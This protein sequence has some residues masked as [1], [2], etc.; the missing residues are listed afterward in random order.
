MAANPALIP[1]QFV[2]GEE[3]TPGDIDPNGIPVD[4]GDPLFQATGEDGTQ[5]SE[6][7]GG[8]LQ[9]GFGPND[10]EALELSYAPGMGLEG[11]APDA[12]VHNA[13]LA[14]FME[15]TDLATIAQDVIEWEQIDQESRANWKNRIKEGMHLLGLIPE[16][17]DGILKN[18]EKV[19]HPLIAEGQVQFQARTMGELVPPTGPA[20]GDVL[21]EST[22]ELEDQA[23]RVADY[24]NYQLM[25]LDPDWYMETDR[26]LFIL[27]GEGSQF[28]KVFVDPLTGR[29]VSRWIRTENFAVPYGATSLHTTPRYTERI[30][31]YRNDM[32]KL[33]AS[34]HYRKV[35]LV[36][37]TDAA[38]TSSDLQEARDQA[39]GEERHQ[40]A[41]QNDT[42]HT[43]LDCVC[44]L[45]LPGF[46][47]TYPLD[48]EDPELAGTATGIALPYIVSVDKDS[49]KVLAIRR[50]WK[51]ND[52]QRL[53]RVQIVH[54]PFLP[55]DG[56]YSYGLWHM[57]GGLG[58]AATGLL[59]TI[60]IGAAFASM[61][62]GF[63][64]KGG[65]ADA[66]IELE[67]GK[68]KDVD[69]SFEE[70]TRLF[71]TP[72]FKE[73]GEAL[74]KV[75]GLVETAAQRFSS[76]TESMVGDASNTGPVGTTVALIEQGSKIYTGIHKRL[77]IAQGQELK[78]L[79]ELNGETLPEEG[80]PYNVKG[81]SR[82]AFRT[83]F[84][85][86]VDVVPVS[87][88]NIFSS[89]QR[90]SMAQTVVQRADVAPDLYDRKEAE[91]RFLDAIKVP[92]PDGVLAKIAQPTRADPVTENA[93]MLV[94]MPVA[95]FV[96]QDHDAH[97]TVV[98]SL[99]DS[100]VT[101]PQGDP[102]AQKVI[103]AAFAHLA[104]HM[105]YGMRAKVALQIGM[106][107]PPMT[108]N[109]PEGQPV[110]PPL[111]PQI[112]N[113]IAQMAA[114]AI[115]AMP[116][117]QQPGG[118]LE[119]RAAQ[120]EQEAQALESERQSIKGEAEKLDWKR[121]EAALMGQ[122]DGMKQ[123]AAGNKIIEEA[124][125]RIEKALGKGQQ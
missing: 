26:M 123:Q 78:L 3:L 112:E 13:N 27:A 7:P 9:V 17:S 34:G 47:D 87:D 89:T 98:Q 113:Q 105:A 45:D 59:K 117:P 116:K 10:E 8:A 88:P 33:Q 35:D 63:K 95:V 14:E 61:Q 20:K 100:M 62:G 74:F 96:D 76:T 42:E 110:T 2:P 23:E 51:E 55:G 67:W 84:D 37:P 12:M 18:V 73:P 31:V 21:G 115:A 4:I 68:Y 41:T 104:E 53:R 36:E 52:P 83:D 82:E 92:D 119:Q 6:L 15:E 43:V 54:Y 66:D 121:R 25:T 109:P 97:M 77:H 57:I 86:R 75:L 94:G 44:E 108:L 5:L 56:F 124:L 38:M 114:M 122:I 1:H 90:I 24:L 102:I 106:Q 99:I 69:M 111:P 91:K 11:M 60:M 93:M 30:P 48:H 80:Y 28:K 32:L 64:A 40:M 118:D 81:G 39:R 72:Q 101:R 85:D 49:Q 125:R 22:K 19:N 120:I 58:H 103:P 71:Y 29:P 65:K 107:L 79:A 16:G 46:E 50:C 70:L